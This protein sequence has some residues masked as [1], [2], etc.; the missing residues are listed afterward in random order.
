MVYITYNSLYRITLKAVE[1]CL[2]TQFS[3]M[4]DKDGYV[5]LAGLARYLHLP[6]SEPTLVHL[7]NLYDTVSCLSVPNTSPALYAL[8]RLYKV[9]RNMSLETYL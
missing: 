7:F 5:R 8:C 6:P 9:E 3:K 2:S 1:E 4:A